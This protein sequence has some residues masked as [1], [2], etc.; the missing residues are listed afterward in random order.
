[1]DDYA[2]HAPTLARQL[3]TIL[4]LME[5]LS[6]QKSDRR[7]GKDR[8]KQQVPLV[9]SDGDQRSGTERRCAA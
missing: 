9:F 8:R 3:G 2:K 1:M 5:C 4:F 7:S 6:G